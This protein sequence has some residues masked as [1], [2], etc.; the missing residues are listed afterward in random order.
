MG[1]SPKEGAQCGPKVASKDAQCYIIRFGPTGA[2]GGRAFPRSSRLPPSKGRS[3]RESFGGPEQVLKLLQGAGP[4]GSHGQWPPE[5]QSFHISSW[6]QEKTR[7][8]RAGK[9]E[10]RKKEKGG[11]WIRQRL[12]ATAPKKRWEETP[13]QLATRLQAAVA[14]CNDE[15]NVSGL[16]RKFTSRLTELVKE[17]AGDRLR[18]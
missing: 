18:T 10:G 11:A 6:L 14:H 17:T 1:V 4:C 2:R 5:F 7:A 16:C 8:T 13:E 9:K 12:H 3:Y 15:Y